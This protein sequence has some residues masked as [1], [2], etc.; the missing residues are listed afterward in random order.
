MGYH[1]LLPKNII[2]NLETVF[3][4]ELQEYILLEVENG[5]QAYLQ[6]IKYIPDLII[7][8]WEMDG[9]NGI[10]VLHS[11]KKN[12][13]TKDIPVIIITN[14]DNL[15]ESFEAGAIDFLYKPL[16]EA[17]LVVRIKSTLSLFKLLKGLIEQSEKLEIQ[18]DLLEMQ[19]MKLE[20]E[21][22]KSDELLQNIL[23]YEIAEQLKNKGAVDVKKYRMTS[24]LFTDFKGFTRISEQLS[25]EEIVKELSIHFEKFE[26][27]ISRHHIEKIKTIGDAF[28]CAGGLPLRNKSNP[29]NTVLA[30]L[31][32]QKFMTENNARKRA[33]N[34]PEWQL[35]IGIHTG[36]VVAGVIGKKKFAYDI[37]GDT[38]NTASRMES[39]GEAGRVNISGTTYKYVKDLFVCEYRGKIEAKNKGEIDMYFVNALKPEYSADESGVIPNEAFRK[40]LSEY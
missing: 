35:R 1:I 39:S 28:M 27:I 34:Q 18:S 13:K 32:I 20:K 8:D 10:D 5:E 9:I 36:R 3:D 30:A 17:E 40:I 38:V 25:P 14:P 24:V 33:A 11:L 37:W 29:I 7:L 22:A 15:E 21:K 31:Q 19:K 6:A 23:P 2:P 12:E 4:H 16:N 26:E